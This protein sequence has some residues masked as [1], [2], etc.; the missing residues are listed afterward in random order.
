MKSNRRQEI[1]TLFILA[2]LLCPTASAVYKASKNDDNAVALY[3][4]TSW[5]SISMTFIH[6]GNESV[7]YSYTI[8]YMTP[9]LWRELPG[10]IYDSGNLSGNSTITIE[11][12][13]EYRFCRVAVIM[14]AGETGL[15]CLGFVLLK[16]IIF[17]STIALDLDTADNYLKLTNK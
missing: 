15:M 3:I 2:I 17:T 4:D 14:W 12:P 8:S 16:H 10:Y 6:D 11:H 9:L 5:G 7:N 13:V 1:I